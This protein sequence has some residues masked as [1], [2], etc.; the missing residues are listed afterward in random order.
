MFFFH[1][2]NR[3]ATQSREM[4]GGSEG[5]FTCHLLTVS[6]YNF[7]AWAQKNLVGIESGYWKLKPNTIS[8][9]N[10]L[11]FTSLISKLSGDS[12]QTLQISQKIEGSFSFLYIF[13]LF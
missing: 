6:A 7:T 11:E 2:L 3:N 13:I 1:L 10:K 9:I 5:S 8:G 12:I 4:E